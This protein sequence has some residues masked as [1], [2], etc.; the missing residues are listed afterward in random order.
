MNETLLDKAR[1]LGEM[2]AATTEYQTMRNLEE[3][4]SKDP[5]I[6]DLYAQYA[7]LRDQMRMLE[8]EGEQD[9]AAIDEL[10]RQAEEV[11]KQVNAKSKMQSVSQ[12]RSA[13]NLMMDKVN[14]ILQAALTG[15]EAYDY[16]TACGSG[17]CEGCQG[18]SVR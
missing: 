17:G 14:R 7:D 3:D 9:A 5:E 11:E 4:A 18:C 6:S 13:F 2:I 16:D 1:E 15:E 8:L 12:A 10:N